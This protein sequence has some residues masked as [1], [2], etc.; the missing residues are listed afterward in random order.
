MQDP[1]PARYV[2]STLGLKMLMA[3]TGVILFGFLIGH[4]AGNLLVFA[5]AQ[6]LNDYSKFLH[7]S[8]GILWGTRIT[9]LV[10][11]VVHIVVSIM[12]TKLK[13]DAR[14]V[15]YLG[16]KPH[17]STYASR[18]MMWSGPIVALFVVYHL[19]HFTT[20]HAHPKFDPDN[21]YANVV[22]GFKSFPVGFTYILAMLAVGLHLSHGL[23]SMLQTVGLNRPHLEPA[24][25]KIAIL[26]SALLVA[27]FIAVPLAVWTEIV[28]VSP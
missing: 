9:L 19:L 14:P 23:W 3:L 12:L 10:A 21:V 13:A 18:T 22:V 1:S 4:V 5:G 16:K 8:P 11:V 24:L 15:P 6:K 20:G 17:G 25:R 27:G 7:H 26:V 28:K 2:R